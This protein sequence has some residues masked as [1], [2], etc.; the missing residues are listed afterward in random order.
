MGS[1]FRG[2]SG[3]SRPGEEKLSTNFSEEKS[4]ISTT[5]GDLDENNRKACVVM[6]KQMQDLLAIFHDRM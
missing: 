1:F 3:I 4:H 6:L 2:R 5:S